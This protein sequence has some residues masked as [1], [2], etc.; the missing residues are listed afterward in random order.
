MYVKVSVSGLTA[1]F[2]RWNRVS[3]C[4]NVSVLDFIGAKDDR[5]GGDNWRCM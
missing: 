3:W 5:D 4:Q 2:S 1:I